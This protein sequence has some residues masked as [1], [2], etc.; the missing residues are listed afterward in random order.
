MEAANKFLTSLAATL[1][2]ELNT[3]EIGACRRQKP[4]GRVLMNHELMESR[5]PSSHGK[6][7]FHKLLYKLTNESKHH[8]SSCNTSAY[9]VHI[10]SSQLTIGD[11][12]LKIS[13][14]TLSKPKH[15]TRCNLDGASVLSRCVSFDELLHYRFLFIVGMV[16]MDKNVVSKGTKRNSSKTRASYEQPFFRRLPVSNG[17]QRAAQEIVCACKDCKGWRPHPFCQFPRFSNS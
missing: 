16:I 12:S 8:C 10:W 2:Q 14:A 7:S 17:Q 6:R 3:G 5:V 11:F 4:E 13:Q 9:S 1:V 15:D